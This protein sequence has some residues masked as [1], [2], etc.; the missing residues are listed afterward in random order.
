MKEVRAGSVLTLHAGT[1]ALDARKA[2]QEEYYWKL[3]AKEHKEDFAQTVEHTT[4]L[5]TDAVRMQM[6]SDIPIST[7]LSGGV[8]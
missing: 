2:L 8:D 5:I 3:E 4:W 1:A 7:F 6:L